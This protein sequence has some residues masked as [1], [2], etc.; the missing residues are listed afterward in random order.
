MLLP[1]FPQPF[2]EQLGQ[3]ASWSDVLS[4]TSVDKR[5]APSRRYWIECTSIV[6][7]GVA[8]TSAEQRSFVSRFPRCPVWQVVAHVR[9]IC[10]TAVRLT[11]FSHF[12]E[13]LDER[14]V[15][16]ARL[17][18]L[19]FGDRFDKPVDRLRFPATL[20]RLTFGTS[21]SQ[22]LERCQLPPGLEQLTLGRKKR[23]PV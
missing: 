11:F 18:D 2:L 13:P 23:V 10:P 14:V 20:K 15:L 16:P 17:T 5:E 12:N 8:V 21:F 22:S 1:R 19:T 3:L 9:Q 6:H 4:L 7:F